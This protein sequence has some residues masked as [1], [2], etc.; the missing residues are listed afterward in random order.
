MTALNEQMVKIAR[1]RTLPMAAEMETVIS[2]VV[3]IAK[4]RTEAEASGAR[5][6]KWRGR[7]RWAKSLAA[8]P[9][10]DAARIGSVLV[11]HNC[12]AD[13]GI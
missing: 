5:R 1:E 6:P 7:K 11:L 13:E 10:S 9:D 8:W 4:E 2:K 3:D 12:Q